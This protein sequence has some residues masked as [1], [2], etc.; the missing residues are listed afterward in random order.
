MLLNGLAYSIQ[1]VA[2]LLDSLMPGNFGIFLIQ[3]VLVIVSLE[4][5]CVPRLRL[6]YCEVVI[7]GWG[8]G[9]RRD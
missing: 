1:S 3:G 7:G 8:R 5:L 9:M 4:S 2:A 6:S